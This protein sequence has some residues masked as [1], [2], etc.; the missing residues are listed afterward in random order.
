MLM[1]DPI[2]TD[3]APKAI[4]P[5]SQAI[6]CGNLVFLSGQIPLN[7]ETMAV[8]ASDFR[9]AAHRVFLNLTAV[10]EAAGGTLAQILKLTIY[11]TNLNDFA[12]LNEVMMEYFQEPYPARSTIQVAALPKDV[13]IEIDAVMTL[14]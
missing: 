7:P 6:R 5:Y 11:L 9:R 14:E 13:A 1:L 12:V 10:C 3:A 4:G 8:D 2:Q